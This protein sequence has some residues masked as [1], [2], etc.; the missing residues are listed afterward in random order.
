M[1]FCDFL[2][3]QCIWPIATRINRFFSRS[4]KNKR[5]PIAGS[6]ITKNK[7]TDKVLAWIDNVAPGPPEKV[8]MKPK[9]KKTGSRKKTKKAKKRRGSKDSTAP[10]Q[11]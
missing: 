3:V 10:A 7:A 8:Y 4:N 11:S 1:W 9:R 5:R 2:V 6:A